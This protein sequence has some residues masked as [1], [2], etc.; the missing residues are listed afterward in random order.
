MSIYGGEAKASCFTI[1]FKIDAVRGAPPKA[2]RGLTAVSQ[3][4][5]EEQRRNARFLKR[6]KQ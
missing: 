3:A 5:F 4:A 2:K 1:V 6:L